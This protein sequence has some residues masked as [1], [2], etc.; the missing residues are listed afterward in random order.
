MGVWTVPRRFGTA[1]LAISLLLAWVDGG[2]TAGWPFGL[3]LLFWLLSSTAALGLAV[4]AAIW[5]ARRPDWSARPH[6]VQIAAAGCLGLLGYVPLAMGLERAWPGPPEAPDDW[7]DRL[8]AAGGWGAALAEL[9]Q[10]GPTYLLTWGLINIAAP[11]AAPPP[12]HRPVQEP[13][14]GPPETAVPPAAATASTPSA[15]TA[16][17]WPPAIGDEVQAVTADLHYLHVRT[18]L[19]QATVLG[20]M[21][22]VERH[23]ALA[24]VPGLRVHR[25]HWVALA[26]VRRVRR[27]GS[28]WVCELLDGQKLP[29]S[30]RRVPEVRELLGRDFVLNEA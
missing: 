17:G 22:A 15:A 30:R 24:G 2:P 7:L 6:G 14:P 28:G 27:T 26:A 3:A 11:V 21:T 29:V 16:L 8:E 19:G 23:F 9:L 12:A 13:T 25:S 10:A 5:L 18:R 4:A 20:S 1:V